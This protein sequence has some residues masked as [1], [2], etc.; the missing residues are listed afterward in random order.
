MEFL[1]S[2]LA[3][4]PVVAVTAILIRYLVE[5]GKK[6]KVPFVVD[7]P[8]F[9]QQALNAVAWI[10][11]GIAAHYGVDGQVIDV[12]QRFTDAFPGIMGLLELVIP[13][14]LSVLG[15][16]AVHELAKKAEGKV[17]PDDPFRAVG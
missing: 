7:N 10:G 16:K 17:Q 4:F 3:L 1:Y 13:A 8:A 9:T 14:F 6:F 11:L 5:A 12:I 2:L 15:T